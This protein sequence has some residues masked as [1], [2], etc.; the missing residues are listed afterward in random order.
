M[1]NC[2]IYVNSIYNFAKK[3]AACKDNSLQAVILDF[4]K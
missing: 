3:T 1:Q 2:I 4:S